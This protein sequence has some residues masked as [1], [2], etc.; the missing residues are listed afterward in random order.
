MVTF[1]IVFI[2]AVDVS[3]KLSIV[4]TAGTK[5]AAETF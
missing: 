3:L 5:N 1:A 2:I 4:P